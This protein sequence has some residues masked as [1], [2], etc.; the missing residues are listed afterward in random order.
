M[1][2]NTVK[3]ETILT[4]IRTFF[5]AMKHFESPDV[6]PHT[7]QQTYTYSGCTILHNGCILCAMQISSNTNR[8][9]G[10]HSNPTIFWNL[11]RVLLCL[12]LLMCHLVCFQICSIFLVD[13][14]RPQLH[15]KRVCKVTLH[16][17]VFNHFLNPIPVVHLVSMF[18][19]THLFRD[20]V[21]FET[22][23]FD[24]KLQFNWILL[25][26]YQWMQEFV[27]HLLL[28]TRAS[29]LHQQVA[30]L[31]YCWVKEI[32]FRNI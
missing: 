1:W 19:S 25:K 27:D 21:L 26:V 32:G 28:I 5:V 14:R 8:T 24:Y 30:R 13:D 6:I 12:S 16:L 31:E 10:S 17:C 15:Q 7:A 3:T 18:C 9:E 22:H 20:F 23:L 4:T 2:K 29:P 11:F